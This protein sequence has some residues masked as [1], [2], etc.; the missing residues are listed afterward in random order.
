MNRLYILLGFTIFI[1]GCKTR[2]TEQISENTIT[3]SDNEL[4]ERHR[5]SDIFEKIT[6]VRLETGDESI[7][8]NVSKV[9]IMDSTIYILDG[10]SM[11]LFMF[12][13]YGQYISKIACRGMGPY[14]YVSP[15]DF[16]VLKNKDILILDET[17]KIIHFKE[18]GTP[19]KT[20]R[21]PFYADALEPLNDSLLVFAGSG[22]EQPVIIW[23][24]RNN[25]IVNKFLEYDKKHGGRGLKPL[26]KY[27]DNVYFNRKYSSTIYKV[28]PE[29]ISTQ[30]FINFGKRN[31]NEHIL[32]GMYG[33]PI[34][35]PSAADINR[36][37]ETKNL[38]TFSFQVEDWKDGMP[39]YVYFSK[40]NGKKI[41][42]I[43]DRYDND[44]SFDRYPQDILGI[45]DSDEMI[46]ILYPAYYLENLSKYDT[47]AMDEAKKQRW[48][49][50]Q[51]QLNGIN[52]FDNPVVAI[53][54]VKNF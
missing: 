45:T 23:N 11:S 44:M 10:Q 26:I 25:K 7:I 32:E 8:G 50:I 52:E 28:T 48:Q 16:T 2:S 38:V 27:S 15:E 35:P 19:Y 41:V 4:N 21:I 29:Q 43:Y 18:D 22:F 36:V 47:T 1:F 46:E 9:V 24:M 34:I 14:E 33:I 51:K 6:L 20:Y 31:I 53:Y 13:I 39:H 42:T 37:T 17:K 30:W 49:N 5:A 3:V 54:S 12:N 40:S